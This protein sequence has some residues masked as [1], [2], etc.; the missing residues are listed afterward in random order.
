MGFYC[1]D[2]LPSRQSGK[3]QAWNNFPRFATRSI[4]CRKCLISPNTLLFAF[5]CFCLWRRK[6][7]FP[8]VKGGEG[9]KGTCMRRLPL[10]SPRLSLC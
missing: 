6:S 10:F 8:V 2:A 9:K 5:P 7:T 1:W 4:K 3:I